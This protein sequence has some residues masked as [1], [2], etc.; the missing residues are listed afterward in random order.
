MPLFWLIKLMRET[1]AKDQ[2][3]LLGEGG[4]MT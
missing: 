2:P 3:L 1:K 4:K